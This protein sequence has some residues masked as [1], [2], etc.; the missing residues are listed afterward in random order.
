[1]DMRNVVVGAV[2]GLILG[3][4]GAL[5]VSS[6]LNDEKLAA[7]QSQ[8][9]AA[10]ASLEKAAQEKKQL[11]RMTSGVSDQVDQLVSSNEELK[12][13]L[14][15]AKQS[16]PA[17][18]TPEAVNPATLAGIVMGMMRGGPGGFQTQQRLFLLQTRLH[19][20]PEQAAAIKEA[21]E[22]DDKARRDLMRQMFGR[23]RG[24]QGGGGNYGGNGGAPPPNAAAAGAINSLDKTL[25]SVLTQ[26][27]QEAYQ[28]VQADEKTARADTAATIQVNQ[29]AP[30][31]Q[32]SDSQKDQVFSALYQVQSTAPD[33]MSL[34]GNPNAMAAL[35][36]QAQVTQGALAKVLTGDQMAIY[37][38][39]AQAIGFGG[40]FGGRRAN[41]GGDP[42]GNRNAT[43]SATPAAVTPAMAT[44]A[45]TADPSSTTAIATTNAPTASD[46]TTNAAPSGDGGT[47]NAAPATN[48]APQ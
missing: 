21:M 22:A 16:S 36:T 38:Q 28:Q 6:Y 9:D 18:S 48:S 43:A 1:M 34:I 4:V 19:L 30:L 29:I 12:K 46:G 2:G 7:I 5:A 39:Q 13:E 20:T 31:L 44:P 3:T 25:A 32:L 26:Q 8:L 41:G 24:G 27:Q 14:A 37:T 35:T 40:G 45:A 47:T 33:P 23:G 15:Q 17:A 11:S 10:N 42:G